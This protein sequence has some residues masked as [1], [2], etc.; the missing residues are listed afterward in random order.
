MG[1]LLALRLRER[2]C[3]SCLSPPRGMS[4]RTTRGGSGRPRRGMGARSSSAATPVRPRWRLMGLPSPRPPSSRAA[5]SS[6]SESCMDPAPRSAAPPRRLSASWPP[7]RGSTPRLWPPRL[8]LALRSLLFWPPPLSRAAM[9]E[10][11]AP[12]LLSES[13]RLSSCG[14]LLRSSHFSFGL[15][16]GGLSLRPGCRSCNLVTY[17]SS[18]TYSCRLSSSLSDNF[19]SW[20]LNSLASSRF[21]CSFSCVRSSRSSASRCASLAAFASFSLASARAFRLAVSFSCFSSCLAARFFKDSSAFCSALRSAE[22][23]IS[24]SCV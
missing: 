16:S 14:V 19:S 4:P 22:K 13:E 6:R 21:C 2:R 23:Q 10:A 3:S 17:S 8:L 9:V 20:L 18:L 7:P 15:F 12:L 11:A 24:I 5:S 1:P